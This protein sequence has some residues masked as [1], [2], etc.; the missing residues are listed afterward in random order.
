MTAAQHDRAAGVM[1]GMAAG[2]ALGAGYEFGE[3]FGEDVPVLMNGGGSF[4]WAPGEWTDDTSMAVPILQAAADGRDLRDEAVLD[5]IVARWVDWAKTAPDVGIQL[6]A[7]LSQTE[8]TASAIRVVAKA[9]HDR[10][11]RSA[12]NGSLMRT[13][14]VALAFL[15]DVEAL[16]E[17]ARAISDLTHFEA[18]AGDACVIWCLAIRH[19]VLTGELDVRVGLDALPV[20]RRNLWQARFLEAESLAPSSFTRNGWVVEALQA[21]WS[22]IY[23]ALAVST[24]A[25]ALRRSL[26]NAVRGGRDTDTVAAI[27]GALVGARFGASAVPASWRRAIH[28]WPGLRGSDLVRLAILAANG[29]DADAYGWPRAERFDYSSYGDVSTLVRHPHDNRVWLGAVGSLDALPDSIDAV[30]SLCRVGSAQVPARISDH[31][32]VW[33]VDSS[34]PSKNPN[35]KFVLEDAADAIAAYRAEGKTVLLHCVQAMSRTPTVAALYSIRHLDV[36]SERALAEVRAALP[37]AN[38][39]RAFR[40]LLESGANSSRRATL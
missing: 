5:E 4:G 38:P 14:P 6:R 12:G 23:R 8:P 20:D 39:K 1:L 7:V 30:V 2:D 29:G 19:A 16:A 26:E 25:T 18:D 13:A 35:L 40:E 27:T 28:G 36:P 21:A 32:E 34:D 31:I 17:A 15:H 10:N 24:D 11:G 33:L 9:H 3:P 37:A 22:S